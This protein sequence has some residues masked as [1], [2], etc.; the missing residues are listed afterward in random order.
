M[1]TAAEPGAIGI[2]VLAAGQG[3]RFGSDKRRAR[4]TD[5]NTLLEATLA[6]IPDALTRRVLVLQPGDDELVERFSGQWQ[7][8]IASDPASGMA[9]SL[10]CGIAMARDWAGTLIALGDMPWIQARTYVG[11]Q[12]A[13]ASHDIVV[14][15]YRGQRGNPAGFRNRFFGEMAEL[16]GDRGAKGLL[17]KYAGDCFEMETGDEGILR[18]VDHPDALIS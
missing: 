18:D 17:Q 10:A 8:C 11:L 9:N 14:P 1:T 2:I 12:Q 4:L 16:A 6:S 7:I 13:L 3:S 5:G 15:T